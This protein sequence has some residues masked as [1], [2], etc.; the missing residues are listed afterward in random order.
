MILEDR[1]KAG[2][3]LTSLLVSYAQLIAKNLILALN[4][5]GALGF[6]TGSLIKLQDGII[7]S[8]LEHTRKKS[9]IKGTAH[10]HLAKQLAIIKQAGISVKAPAGERGLHGNAMADV[11]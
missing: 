11:N 8:A 3:G 9:L 2:V 4:D 5:K 6:I 1:D 10:Y 7:G